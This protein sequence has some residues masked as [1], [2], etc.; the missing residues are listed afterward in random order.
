MGT[1]LKNRGI[2]D[3]GCNGGAKHQNVFLLLSEIDKRRRGVVFKN[4]KWRKRIWLWRE[5]ADVNIY[6]E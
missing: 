1:H 6:G 3:N 2:C 4:I 5:G